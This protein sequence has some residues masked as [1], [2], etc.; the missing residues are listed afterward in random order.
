MVVYT[1]FLIFLFLLIVLITIGNIAYLKRVIHMLMR[2]IKKVIYKV[3]N[4]FNMIKNQSF[5]GDQASRKMNRIFLLE[6]IAKILPVCSFEKNSNKF[7]YVGYL[8]LFIGSL[9]AFH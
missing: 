9:L 3:I 2:N 8:L 7:I 4:I 5:K 1:M 6:W